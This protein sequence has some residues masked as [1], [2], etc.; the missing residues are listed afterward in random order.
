M[1]RARAASLLLPLIVATM[2]TGC[3]EDESTE[4]DAVDAAVVF[5]LD[6]AEQ[7]EGIVP[8]VIAR[9][10]GLFAAILDGDSERLSGSLR[11]D[12]TWNPG[13]ARMG[14]GLP[15]T[16]A[17]DYLAVLA[18]Y[19]PPSLAAVPTVFDAQVIADDIVWIYAQRPDGG[20]GIV[21]AWERQDGAWRAAW[22]R[23]VETGLDRW[24]ES[25][26]RTR[27]ANAR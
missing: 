19:R 4:S 22:A 17:A 2:F 23:D 3:T 11:R 8:T 16:P 24:Q 27:A 6:R 1:T 18:G 5:A 10:R 7:A 12:F 20:G 21:T 26:R 15:A 25:R 9:Q 13:Y 14:G